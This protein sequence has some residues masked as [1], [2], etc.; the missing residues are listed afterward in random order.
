[1]STFTQSHNSM[2]MLLFFEAN[3]GQICQ[4]R[5]SPLANFSL[6]NDFTRFRH[7]II[8]LGTMKHLIKL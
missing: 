1:M 7:K 2:S 8:R 6:L 4:A 3:S 5:F